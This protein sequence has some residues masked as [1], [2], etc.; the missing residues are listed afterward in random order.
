MKKHTLFN[1][2]KW[3]KEDDQ[4]RFR[5]KL[6]PQDSPSEFSPRSGLQLVNPGVQD[7]PVDTAPLRIEKLELDRVF[8]DLRSKFFCHLEGQDR[9]DVVTSWEKLKD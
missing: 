6:L 7:D 2:F 3:N 4:V 1:S 8:K 5:A 9:M